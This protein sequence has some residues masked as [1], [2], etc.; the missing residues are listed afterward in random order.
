M[1]FT[2]D[3]KPLP[4]ETTPAYWFIFREN[5]LLVEILGDSTSI[6]FSQNLS[7]FNMSLELKQPICFGLLDNIPCYFIEA[8]DDLEIPKKMSFHSIRSLYGQL[9]EDLL[10]IAGRAFQLMV[11]DKNS[12][13]CGQCGTSTEIEYNERAK[14]CP[15]CDLLVFPRI[16]PAIIVGIIDQ[17]KKKILLANGK[18]FPTNFYSVLAGFVEPGETLEE[19]IEREVLEEVRIEVKN[20]RYFGSQSW[21]FPDSLMI[22]FLADYANGQI[23]I[24]PIEINDANWFPAD[25]LPQIPGEIS[26]ARKIIDWF[27]EKY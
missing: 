10:W 15:N 24:N 4:S 5:L 26:I 14:K 16:S 19:C 6:P 2:F 22:G 8:S 25:N 20:I 23:T 12:Q 11:W 13:Y 7:K 17:E 1:P 9:N 18:R 27:V 3:M 21:P